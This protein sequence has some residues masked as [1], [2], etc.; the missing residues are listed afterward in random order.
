[1]TFCKIAYFYFRNYSAEF[2]PYL[3]LEMSTQG[4]RLNII[5]VL[6]VLWK[7]CSDIT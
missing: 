1:M 3:L 5:P 6:I 2:K 4:R 7:V